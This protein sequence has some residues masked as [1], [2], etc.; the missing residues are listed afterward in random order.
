VSPKTLLRALAALG[1]LVVLWG[2]FALFRGRLSET[3]AGLALPAL[4]PADVERIEIA[5]SADTVRLARGGAGW[6]VNGAAADPDEVRKFLEV[7]TDSV[8]SGELVARNPASHAR[9]GVDTAGRRV[10]IRKGEVV[11]L[12]LVLGGPGAGYGSTYARPAGTDAVYLVRGPAA[13]L[14]RRDAAA[15]R[16]RRVAGIPADSVGRIALRRGGV[17]TVLARDGDGWRVDAAAADTA[18]VRRLLGALADIM[19]IG[20]AG[21]GELDSLDFDRPDRRITVLSPA[22]DTLLDLLV[23]STAAGFRVRRSGSPDVFQLDFWRVNELIP[24]VESLRASGSS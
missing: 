19:A 13:G 5:G 18:G 10:V 9:L 4:S 20:F 17:E 11:L 12:D 16:N 21:P 2:A 3:S 22:A 7:L 6:T 23:D 1:G 24:P 15:W 14:A 8:M